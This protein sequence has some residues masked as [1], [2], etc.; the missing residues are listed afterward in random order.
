[1]LFAELGE[2]RTRIHLSLGS[3]TWCHQR[4]L[5][6]CAKS[7][8]LNISEPG[9]RQRPRPDPHPSPTLLTKTPSSFFAGSWQ[10]SW[11]HRYRDTGCQAEVTQ[12]RLLKHSDHQHHRQDSVTSVFRQ[13]NP[14]C[15]CAQ[16]RRCSTPRWVTQ[17]ITH[18]P[19][20]GGGGTTAP[21]NCYQGQERRLLTLPFLLGLTLASRE[22]L[23]SV[24]VLAAKGPTFCALEGARLVG[25]GSA[26]RRKAPACAERRTHKKRP[27]A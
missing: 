4:S 2:R 6:Q 17:R 19:Q 21:L 23:Q 15:L 27:R 8:T 13:Q 5:F 20:P 3:P 11:Q 14:R 16:L 24:F 26:G 25:G 22:Q 18:Q 10:E 12:S 9:R 1:M 7:L